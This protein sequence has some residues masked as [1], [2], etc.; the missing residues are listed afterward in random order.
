MSIKILVCCQADRS[1]SK[2][3]PL[4]KYTLSQ[5]LKVIAYAEHNPATPAAMSSGISKY[6]LSMEVH[7]VCTGT[8]ISEGWKTRKWSDT[9]VSERRACVV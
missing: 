1:D 9:P 2:C 6:G 7:A 5:K 8:S 4:G 3:L